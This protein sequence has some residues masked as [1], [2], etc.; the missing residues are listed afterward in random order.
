[1]QDIVSVNIIAKAK[2]K[3]MYTAVISNGVKSY[4]GKIVFE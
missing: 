4:T 1:M 2:A 3:G